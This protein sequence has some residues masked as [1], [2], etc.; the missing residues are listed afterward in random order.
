MG[1]TMT[2]ADA[3]L[4]RLDPSRLMSEAESALSQSLEDG[5][6]AMVGF[7]ETRGTGREWKHTWGNNPRAGS[8]PGRDDTGT[9]KS[10]V[11]GPET[12]ERNKDTVTGSLGWA[13]GSPEYYQHQEYGFRN[14]LTGT[15]VEEMRALRD[16]AEQTTAE[17]LP[18]LRKLGRRR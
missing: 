17:L 8:F 10:A 14:V 11:Q 1:M 15:Y 4:A 6:S 3:F 7:I 9:M 12:V 2:G 13:D 5:K 18:R 16:A